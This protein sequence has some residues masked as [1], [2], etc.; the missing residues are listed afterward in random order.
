MS[1]LPAKNSILAAA[2][3]AFVGGVLFAS[4]VDFPKH[5]SA[6][7]GRI[8]RTAS[9]SKDAGPA[10]DLSGGFVSVAE[11]VTPAVV[12]IQAERDPRRTATTRTPRGRNAP[13]GLEEFFQQFDPRQQ[14]PRESGGTGLGLA[15]TKHIAQRHGGSFHVHSAL[16]EGS[17][18]SL[19]FPSN[20]VKLEAPR[21]SIRTV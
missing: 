15:I 10:A 2:S 18:F 6:A 5:S 8:L 1:R 11:K 4:A 13:P 19:D 3:A 16:G 20:R 7:Q 14:Q 12:S 21:I 17:C 9:S